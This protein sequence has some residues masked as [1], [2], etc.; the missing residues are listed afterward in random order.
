M[1]GIGL[2]INLFRVVFLSN[3]ITWINYYHCYIK[4]HE[5]IQVLIKG[6]KKMNGTVFFLKI[7]LHSIRIDV[8]LY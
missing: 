7:N 3:K 4:N 8:T 6:F 2:Y 5:R 1:H